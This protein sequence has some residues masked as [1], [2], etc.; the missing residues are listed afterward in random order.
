MKISELIKD[1]Q[2][3]MAEHGNAD[4]YDSDEVLIERVTPVYP[5]KE[6]EVFVVDKEAGVSFFSLE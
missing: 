3:A 6:G 2:R 4:V 1:L 5:W